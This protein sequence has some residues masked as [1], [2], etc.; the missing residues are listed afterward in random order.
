MAGILRAQPG[1]QEAIGQAVAAAT[2]PIAADERFSPRDASG[3]L[4]YRR[5][6]RASFPAA[7]AAST[8]LLVYPGED[9]ELTMPLTVRHAG[10]PAHPGEVSLPGGAVDPGDASREAA[11][12]REA[13]EEVGL[14]PETVRIA[15]T[16]DDIWIPVSNF[17]LRPF[18]GT[19]SIR[20]TLVPQTDEVAEIVELPLRLILTDAIVGEEE[21]TG[22]SWV[23]RAAVY[24]HAGQRIWGATARTLAM[25]AAVL[26][27][28]GIS[29]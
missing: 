9:G 14:E 7:R 2:R 1:W 6:D 23:L 21:I 29:E 8:L 5:W 13:H 27:E 12:L 24:R 10:L 16:L 25:F 22:A 19:A 20:P 11:A 17:E 28:A 15:G 18:V 4:N 26:A 3:R